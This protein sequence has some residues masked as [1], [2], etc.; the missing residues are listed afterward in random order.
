MI[1]TRFTFFTE[2]FVIRCNQV[3]KMFRSGH[4]STSS[5]SAR[6]SCNFGPQEEIAIWILRKVRVET[7]LTRTQFHFLLATS[8]VIH[9]KNWECLDIHAQG[10]LV[11]L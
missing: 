7:M 6:R 9:E 4:D 1:S 3:T 5:F 8:L 2:N 11:A 10:F